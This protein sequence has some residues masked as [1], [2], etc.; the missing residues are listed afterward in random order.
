MVGSFNSG[1][2][3]A[4]LI[5]GLNINQYDSTG[6][7]LHP[8]APPKLA[9]ARVYQSSTGMPNSSTADDPDEPWRPYITQFPLI[10]HFDPPSR[11][12]PK[13]RVQFQDGASV[14][15]VDVVVFATGYSNSLPF[16][17]V[18]DEPWRSMRPLDEVIQSEEREGGDEWEVGGLR[19]LKMRGLDELLI[20]P[21]GDRSLA[22]I[23]LGE[24]PPFF[25]VYRPSR[26]C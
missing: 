10:D 1:S 15:D 9:F 14:D 18:T 21:E 23:G 11:S 3:I 7:P 16:C 24:S 8:D 6:T 17:K 13:G 26:E 12:H 5:G 25:T 19:G 22:Y 4:R 2:D 20:F